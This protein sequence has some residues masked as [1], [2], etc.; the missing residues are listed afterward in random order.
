MI[1]D[2]IIRIEWSMS[3]SSKKVIIS[4]L[5][6][7]ARKYKFCSP[8]DDPD[9]ITAVT[10]G[11]RHLVIKLKRLASPILPAD[12]AS[13][14]N[15][16]D[17]EPENLY[18]CWDVDAEIE[19]LLPDIEAALAHV[20]E[21]GARLKSR[22][23][24]APKPLPVPVCS[25]VGSILGE[26]IYSHRAIDRLFYEAGAVGEAPLGSCTVKC[27][28]WLKRLHDDVPDP[29]L[30]LGKVLEKFMEVDG[31]VVTEAQTTGRKRIREIL[32]KNGLA[33]HSGGIIVGAAAALPTKSLRETLKARDLSEVDKE[34][35]RAQTHVESDPPA[36]IAA[37]CSILES[38]F[39]VY[40]EDNNLEMPGDQSLKPLW[41]TVSKQLGFDPSA[42][43]DD[44]IKKILSGMTSVV[45]GIG[46]LRTHRS[47][48][49]GQGRRP[50]RI[51]SR[52]ARLAIHASHTL[53]GFVLE[54]WDERKTK[55]MS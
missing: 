44:D 35:E 1:K 33:Y 40:I 27:E 25:V 17:V 19:A 34:F 30:V 20:D 52:H 18:S 22:E 11:Y 42:I 3:G 14:L 29:A 46:S 16:L 2:V 9:E 48:A 43:E 39:K 49:H 15:A 8:S 32:A 26:F 10:S 6:E 7:S 54:T 45:D 23:N 51:Q 38:L 37:A 31:V 53:V 5:L 21:D 12:I 36:A 47:T 13:R 41:K 28:S 55:G 50:Y 4:D 24:V